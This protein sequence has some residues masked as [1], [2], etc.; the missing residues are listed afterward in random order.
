MTAAKKSI[1]RGSRNFIIPGWSDD[2]QQLFDEFQKTGDIETGKRLLKKLDENRKSKWESKMSSMD[3]AKSSKKALY[4]CMYVIF[5][6]Q[7]RY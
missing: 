7:F 1:P 3:F 6:Q 2:S 4:V 5:I